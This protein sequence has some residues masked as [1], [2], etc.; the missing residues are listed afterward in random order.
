MWDVQDGFLWKDIFENSFGENESNQCFGLTNDP[1]QAFQ[2][3]TKAVLPLFLI[4]FC[5]PPWLRVK[6]DYV[7][8]SMLIPMPTKRDKKDK[9]KY[10]LDVLIEPFLDDFVKLNEEGIAVSLPNGTEITNRACLLFAIHDLRAA[11]LLTKRL[12][13]DNMFLHPFIFFPFL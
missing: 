8:L 10:N 2:K 1:V 3:G 6:R 9:A 12:Q 4:N 13:V 11:S 5:L 7:F